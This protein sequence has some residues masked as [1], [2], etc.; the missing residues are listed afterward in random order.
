MKITSQLKFSVIGLGVLAALN[1]G[2]SQL[3]VKGI[4]SDGSAV[5]KSGIVRGASQRAIKLTLGDSA[6]DDVIAVVDK[7]IDGLQNGNAELD[8]KKP[9]DSTFIKDME[10]VA[11]EW[12]ALKKLT[13]R[14]PSKS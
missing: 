9:T 11:T 8:L 7:M 10:A 2:I 6:P 13:K 4:T 1:A 3:T 12:G 14:L 5:N